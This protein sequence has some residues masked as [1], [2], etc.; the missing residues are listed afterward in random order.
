MATNRKEVSLYSSDEDK[1][2]A[3]ETRNENAD[4]YFVYAVKTTGVYAHPSAP[5]RLP[6]RYNVEFF[7]T[8]EEAERAGY[9]I[10]RRIGCDK[11]FLNNRHS[12]LVLHACRIIESSDPQPKL[13][14]L[15]ES[16]GLSTTHFHRIF[17]KHTG[18]TPKKYASAVR[19]K[20]VRNRL[21]N[22]E[23]K[24]TSDIYDSG[25]SS[26]SRFYEKAQRCLGMNANCYKKGGKG[27]Q[28]LFSVGQCSIGTILVAKSEK[29]ICAISIGD[30][31]EKLINEFQD[32]FSSAELT[33]RKDF[34]EIVS[35][36]VGFIEHP[37]IGFDLPLDIQGTAFQE[38]VWSTLMEI[39]PGE[40]LTYSEVAKRIG[41]PK[42]TRAVAQACGANR[43]AVAIPCHRVIRT[44]GDLSGYRWGIERKKWLIENESNSLEK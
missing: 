40:T 38:R 9:R 39:Q 3:V 26:S 22:K 7:N 17:K 5:F 14:D 6:K 37:K 42:S 10:H 1:W 41:S 19:A 13:E 20:K 15:A 31:P 25:F 12:A 30:D 27:A 11:N 29:G 2:A 23:T 34:D 16:V 43:L 21:R 28:I 8:P 44:N 32:Q 24:I 35:K 33:T 18:L 36:V 4:G